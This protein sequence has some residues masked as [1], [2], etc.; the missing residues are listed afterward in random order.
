MFHMIHL[1][2]VIK[3]DC[4]VR[5]DELFRLEEFA[6]RKER[7]DTIVRNTLPDT[8]LISA[9]NGGAVMRESGAKNW[10]V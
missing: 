10:V 4:I 6:R 7:A 8:C 9:C 1:D 5:R 2:G 3:V